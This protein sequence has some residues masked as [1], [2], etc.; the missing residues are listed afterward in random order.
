MLIGFTKKILKFH[1]NATLM[2]FRHYKD[3]EKATNAHLLNRYLMT[4]LLKY[5]NKSFN[6]FAVT[7]SRTMNNKTLF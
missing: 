6:I 3:E 4:Q 1:S 5:I 2:E 7:E